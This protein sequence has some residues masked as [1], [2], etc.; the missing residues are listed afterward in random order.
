MSSGSFV[1]P[2]NFADRA[3]Q[4]LL[5]PP[6]SRC[7]HAGFVTLQPGAEVGVHSTKHYEEMLVILSGSGEG[8]IAGR[9]PLKLTALQIAY[10]SP[11]T[12][13]NVVNTGAE[14]LRYVYVVTEVE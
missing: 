7:L 1:K 2:L 3:H 14:V 4:P 9:E 6:A 8:R 5:E 13:H 11:H 10:I 12:E